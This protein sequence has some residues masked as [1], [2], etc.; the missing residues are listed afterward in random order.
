MKVFKPKEGVDTVWQS[1]LAIYSARLSSRRTQ[2]RLSKIIGTPI[3]QFMTIRNWNTT[4]RLLKMI[5]E[6]A[7]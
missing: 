1:D 5:E 3:Y 2:S 6:L 7:S 4:T